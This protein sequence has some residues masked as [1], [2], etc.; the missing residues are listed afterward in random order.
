MSFFSWLWLY[1][2]IFFIKNSDMLSTKSSAINQWQLE[3]K[4]DLRPCSCTQGCGLCL[5]PVSPWKVPQ[6]EWMTCLDLGFT[7]AILVQCG[8]QVSGVWGVRLGGRLKVLQTEIVLFSA[9][10]GTGPCTCYPTR[11]GGAAQRA[12]GLNTPPA[13]L[14][15]SPRIWTLI[16]A[17]MWSGSHG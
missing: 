2:L 10:Q 7:S 9:R 11:A 4:V 16:N 13:F 15:N 6:G 1:T 8:A 12:A 5:T 17:A 14:C 3:E